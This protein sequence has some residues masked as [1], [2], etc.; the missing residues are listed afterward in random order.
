MDRQLNIHTG[1]EQMGFNASMHEHRFEVTPYAWLD[2]LF[3][4]H[5]LTGS[6]RLV[7][8]GSGKGRLNFYAHHLFGTPSTGV[9]VDP[10]LHEAALRNLKR[11]KGNAE[12]EFSNGYA[13]DYPIQAD[14]RWFYFFNPF[15]DPIF[16]KV[17]GRI[18]KSVGEHPR[19]VEV[20]L[21]YPSV[22][23]T[24][25]L[26]RRTAFEVIGDIPLP[27]EARDLRERFLVYRLPLWD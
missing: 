14:D 20:L 6:G 16:M 12:I 9:E 17:I 2:V 1:G 15:S 21:F 23:Y 7:D 4:Q 24:D 8:F 10:S 5:P 19:E 3:R 26:E 11:L 18:L 22:E 13:Q 25:F 27:D